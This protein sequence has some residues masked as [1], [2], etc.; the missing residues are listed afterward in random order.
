MAPSIRF[1][2]GDT[3]TTNRSRSDIVLSSA[4]TVNALSVVGTAVF[5]LLDRP[6]G[7]SA[8][9]SGSGS[10]R[11]ITPD[12]RGTYRIRIVDDNDD[13][14]VIHNFTVRTPLFNLPIPAHNERADDRAN[15]ADTDPGTWVDSSETNEGGHF[16]GWHPHLLEFYELA[17]DI[18]APLL[19][20]PVFG[21]HLENNSTT[22]DEIVDIDP[23]ICRSDDNTRNMVSSSTVSVD[24]TNS[25][26]NGLDTGSVAADTWYAVYLIMR[27]DTGAVGGLISA[28]FSS[29]TLP[30]NYTKKRYLGPIKTD[31][32][33][34]IRT[35][36]MPKGCGNSRWIYWK[37]NTI[38]SDNADY[39]QW[40]G[41][42][43]SFTSTTRSAATRVAPGAICQQLGMTMYAQPGLLGNLDCWSA[44]EPSSGD[45]SI[46]WLT[47]AGVASTDDMIVS[48]MM[49]LPVASDRVIRYRISGSG[50]GVC[51]IQAKGFQVVI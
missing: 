6:A 12:V 31:S 51:Y 42:A 20:L 10:T 14:E 11:T 28:S 2:Q 18:I 33:S 3:G 48:S 47:Y 49:I 35:F 27:P 1:D 13:S 26:L 19:A 46:Q 36:Y 39:L 23:G 45:G 40:A 17:E 50:D 34:D 30:T 5:A 4:V 29:P 7:S 32:S 8:A 21:L 9:L 37:Q 43:T 16:K 38:G 44:V 22:P 24:I 15:E 25:G 41:S